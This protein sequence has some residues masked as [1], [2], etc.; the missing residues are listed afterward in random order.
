MPQAG[1]PHW[2]ASEGATL[3]RKKQTSFCFLVVLLDFSH[4]RRFILED[5]YSTGY[6]RKYQCPAS[7]VEQRVVSGF[8]I[9]A[10]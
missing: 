8:Q 2:N 3:R 7:G 5:A 1:Y 10:E 6:L 4:A 9:S